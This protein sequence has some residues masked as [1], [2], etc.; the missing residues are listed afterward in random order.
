MTVSVDY[1]Y[2]LLV[3]DRIVST[4]FPNIKVTEDRT[5]AALQ[6]QRETRFNIRKRRVHSQSL[7][8]LIRL[9]NWNII[10]E[11]CKLRNCLI[12]LEI[13]ENLLS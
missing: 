4:D 9:R 3:G 11:S 1:F 12:N 5:K 10:F 6:G 13:V 8:K 7:M 2:S